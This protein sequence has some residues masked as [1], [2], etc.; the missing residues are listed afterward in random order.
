MSYF[1]KTPRE[2]ALE[3]E[4]GQMKNELNYLRG[5]HSQG[6]KYNYSAFVEP[7]ILEMSEPDSA[8]IDV[9]SSIELASDPYGIHVLVTDRRPNGCHKMLKYHASAK[10]IM[11]SSDRG[12]V[13][14]KMHEELLFELGHKAW[15]E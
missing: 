2:V 1:G 8:T 10:V 7:S 5:F 13:I 9:V 11:N 4:I 12:A 15:S 6:L 3:Y 14:A